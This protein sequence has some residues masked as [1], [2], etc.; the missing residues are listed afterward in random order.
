M[1][2]YKIG[3]TITAET[4]FSIIAKFLPVEELQ[5][6][7]LM[8]IVPT[9][10]KLAQ[11]SIPTLPRRKRKIERPNITNLEA[12]TNR[13]MLELFSDGQPHKAVELKPAFKR[14]NYSVNSIG[15][16]LNS[17]RKKGILEQLGDGTW[18]L[19][20]VKEDVA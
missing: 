17:L 7:E 15:S 9:Q 5:I 4:L 18:R 20:K 2:K 10:S 3:F 14:E 13:I 12:G 11:Q 8:P 16:R 19:I 1:I 6:E